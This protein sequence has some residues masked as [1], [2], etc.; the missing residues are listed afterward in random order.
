MKKEL[1]NELEE[2]KI[3]EPERYDFIKAAST[4]NDEQLKILLLV[5]EDIQEVGVEA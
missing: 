4:L 3:N 2:I 5:V 1:Y